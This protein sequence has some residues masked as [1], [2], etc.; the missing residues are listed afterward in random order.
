[1]TYV[2]LERFI[3]TPLSSRPFQYLVVN[4]FLD[5]SAAALLTK[6]FPFVPGP[7]N[8]PS[9]QVPSN[10]TFTRLLEDLRSNDLKQAFSDKFK[11][12]LSNLHL[13]FGIR[14]W[15]GPHDGRIHTDLP[16]KILTGLLYLNESVSD[17]VG[18]LRFLRSENIDDF[19]L[20][21]PPKLGTLVAFKRSSCS[22]HGYLPY[23]GQ[24]KVLQFN[25]YV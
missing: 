1:M 17:K 9:D 14:G 10:P 11:T 13:K 19:F 7:G 5:R 4:D 24:R 15:S 12:D 20:E 25:W 22:Y 21:I 6:N 8:H 18:N 2:S 16:E 3:A 23:V